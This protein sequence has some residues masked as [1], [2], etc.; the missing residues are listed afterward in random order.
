MLGLQAQAGVLG[1]DVTVL[2][3][4]RSIRENCRNRI[5]P[6]VASSP[7]LIPARW[8]VPLRAPA[9]CI[10]PILPFRT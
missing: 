4:Q 10:T 5:A 9:S 2:A 1:V 7:R 3:V 8:W 6:R